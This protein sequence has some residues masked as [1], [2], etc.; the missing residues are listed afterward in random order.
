MP[1]ALQHGGGGRRGGGRRGLGWGGRV[2]AATSVCCAAAVCR[3]LESNCGC[4]R[5]PQ[6]LPMLLVVLCC[7]VPMG[8]C[9]VSMCY[10]HSALYYIRPCVCCISSET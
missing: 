3:L 1:A 10:V 4:L 5:L 6:L 8:Q 7:A 9:G 2:A